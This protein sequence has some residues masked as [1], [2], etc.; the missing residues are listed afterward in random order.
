MKKSNLLENY[1][2]FTLFHVFKVLAPVITIP[3]ITRIFSSGD[4]GAFAYTHSIANAFALIGALGIKIYGSRVIA[5][6]RDCIKQR[7][8]VFWELF[9]INLITNLCA[10]S[11]YFI[12]IQF[13]PDHL[14]SLYCIL[15]FIFLINIFEINWFFM[16]I[17]D[18]KKTS[19]RLFLTRTIGTLAIFLF[20]KQSGDLP[21]YTFII[22]IN[23]LL[24]CIFLWCYIKKHIKWCL[25][26]FKNIF[27][28]LKPNFSIFVPLIAVY[29]FSIIDKI[30]LGNMAGLSQVGL[31][32]MADKIIKVII[33]L[34]LTLGTVML[35]RITNSL[36]NEDYEK[37]SFYIEKSFSAV[38]YLTIPVAIG[39]I[40]ISDSFI[41]W[42]FG[43]EF[44][45]SSF[46]V[47][48]LSISIVF[49][50]WQNIANLQVLVPFKKEKTCAV[51]VL[52]GLFLKA[53]L[54]FIAIP[55]YKA[56]GAAVSTL[57]TE[58]VL[59]VAFIYFANPYIQLHR[60]RGSL[61]KEI[62]IFSFATISFYFPV[63]VIGSY[64]K[65]GLITNI[66]QV[67][68]G[69]TIYFAMVTLL[70]SDTNK[71]IMN[72]ISGI[73]NKSSVSNKLSPQ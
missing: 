10:F 48:I 39:L 29:L 2:Y 36:A 22:S 73:I 52:L 59:C 54:S 51:I 21:I 41:P 55:L 71:F 47:S 72:K 1:I 70:K 8:E 5:H 46:L 15:S 17:E 18:F 23:G 6:S 56:A 64:M 34:A 69:I 32:E 14:K 38:S 3:Y 35:P 12:F 27:S 7:S 28:H 9:F 42:F 53:G 44:S 37:V 20:V 4:I 66:L 26:K 68:V 30:M 43:P 11:L 61:L 62:G 31:Y 16:G 40:A 60:F 57:I 24:G 19:A 25:P 50:A 45:N 49:I 33:P 63:N 58:L 67:F 13:S 65:A